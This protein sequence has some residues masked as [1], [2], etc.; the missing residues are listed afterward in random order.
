[1]RLLLKVILLMLLSACGESDP[2]PIGKLV[3]TN[4][5]ARQVE[6]IGVIGIGETSLEGPITV[7][8]SIDG[9]F[10]SALVPSNCKV[11]WRKLNPKEG[12]QESV[13]SLGHLA[14]TRLGGYEL[15]LDKTFQWSAVA[16][17]YPGSPTSPKPQAEQDG[18]HQPA[19]RPESKVE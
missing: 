11:R 6:V 14:G 8:S 7:G 16:V 2:K 19:T 5:S 13:V 17:P 4:G 18:A 3:L 10:A 9:F 1:M 15:V 12:T